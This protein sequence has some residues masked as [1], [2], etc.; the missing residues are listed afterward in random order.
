ML[1]GVFSMLY[2]SIGALC[3]LVA[4]FFYWVIY[5]DKINGIIISVAHM[6]IYSLWLIKEIAKSSLHVS[7]KMWKLDPEISPQVLWI[8]VN[9][10]DD[11]AFTIYANSITLTPGT[12]TIG[13][14]AEMLYVHS[15]TQEDMDELKSGNMLNRVYKITK[16]GEK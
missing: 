12:V 7:L 5:K 13:T 8:P 6:A 4:V 1:S 16:F 10:K 9:F 15:L 2:L 11:I 3:C 14:N